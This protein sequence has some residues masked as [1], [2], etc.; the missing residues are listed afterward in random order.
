MKL[1]NIRNWSTE[2]IS[3][4]ILYALITLSVVVFCMFY[5]IGYNRPY[6]EDPNFNDPLLTDGLLILMVLLVIA[7]MCIAVWSI[8]SGL[9]K[10]G[11]ADRLDNNI[12]I[13]KISYS[14]SI[15]TFVLMIFTFLVGSSSMM[16]IN[17]K[18]YVEAF[19]LKTADMFISSS[20][21]LILVAI[22]AVVFGT[23]RYYRKDRR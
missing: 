6:A 23:T 14:V 7:T 21:I 11:K 5:L 22:F 20:L 10:R 1:S 8:Y 15:G 17:G 3:Q 16:M 2:R 18:Q 9:R 4:R 19:W 13:K 12:P